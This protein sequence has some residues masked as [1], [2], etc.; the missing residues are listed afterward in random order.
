M[1]NN[2][3]ESKRKTQRST[4]GTVFSI[5]L[6]AAMIGIAVFATA[7]AAVEQEEKRQEKIEF[8]ETPEEA[9]P[10]PEP[11]NEP[12]PPPPPDVVAQAPPPK[13]FQV[14]TP[15]IDIP[16]VIPDIDLSKKVTNELDFTGRGTQGG[17]DKGV[18][19]APPPPVAPVGD[20]PYFEFQVE[21]QVSL[22]PGT[23]GPRYPEMLRSAAVTGSVSAQFVVGTDGR[24]EMDTFKVLES[25]HDQ[26]T[27]ALRQALPRMRYFPAEI[28]GRP[29]K[30]LV[31]QSFSFTLDR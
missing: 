8:V 31:Q 1:F 24:V 13:G 20:Q 10:E 19:G 27:Q 9:P 3:I 21:K 26:F 5:V 17:T 7:N 12:P 23:A 22:R 6:H 30:Q 2:L 14:L 29:V 11:V 4:G 25:D 16:D 28:G 18:V 15:P